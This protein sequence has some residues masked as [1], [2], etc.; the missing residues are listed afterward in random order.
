MRF[1]EAIAYREL[2]KSVRHIAENQKA[3]LGTGINRDIIAAASHDS[4]AI[5]QIFFVR[6]GKLIGREHYHLSIEP[7]EEGAKYCSD[8]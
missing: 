6:D 8:L 4:E 1:E 5:A 3:T 2:V 7:E